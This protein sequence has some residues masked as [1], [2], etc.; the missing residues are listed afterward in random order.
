[1]SREILL[2]TSQGEVV[3]VGQLM[4]SADSLLAPYLTPEQVELFKYGR[5][6]TDAG[7]V[8]ETLLGYCNFLE[9]LKRGGAN[10]N[11]KESEVNTI[12]G[13]LSKTAN[14]LGY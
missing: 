6:S 3:D 2:K 10:L 7:L 14:D 4:D 9:D 11:G 8:E 12:I 1:M 5:E 13:V